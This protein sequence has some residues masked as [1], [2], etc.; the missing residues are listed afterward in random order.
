MSK[1]RHSYV[2]DNEEEKQKKKRLNPPPQ[3]SKAKKRSFVSP[4]GMLVNPCKRPR[5]IEQ[6]Q[7]TS[8][9]P[10]QHEVDL[11][12]PMREEIQSRGIQQ[13]Q[14]ECQ[15]LNMQLHKN[16]YTSNC[17]T[18]SKGEDEEEEEGSVN[19]VDCPDVDVDG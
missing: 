13:F 17:N 7:C 2:D 1:K 11:L 10:Y 14:M 18:L 6:I 5:L 8:I 15:Q 12:Q 16:L 4:M 9:V 19:D 3:Q